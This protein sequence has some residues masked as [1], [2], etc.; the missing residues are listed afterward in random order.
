MEKRG[1]LLITKDLGAKVIGP[2]GNFQVV[3]FLVPDEW[4]IPEA[5]AAVPVVPE[6]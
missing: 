2:L 3:L 5:E 6:Q 4:H 1:Q